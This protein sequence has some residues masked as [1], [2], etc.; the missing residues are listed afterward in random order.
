[1]KTKSIIHFY[2]DQERFQI[3]NLSEQFGFV[4]TFSGQ[5]VFGFRLNRVE[6]KGIAADENYEREEQVKK[7]GQDRLAKN[8]RRNEKGQAGVKNEPERKLSLRQL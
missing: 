1:M 7:S 3:Q 4:K 2:W 8:D 6:N 5:C